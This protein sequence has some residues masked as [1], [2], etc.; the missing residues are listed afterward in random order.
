MLQ[1]GGGGRSR[2]LLNHIFRYKGRVRE[3]RL[4]ADSSRNMKQSIRRHFR[5]KGFKFPVK[6][7]GKGFVV[8]YD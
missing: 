6:L 8:A 1:I 4:Q 2:H 5:K 7:G 3:H